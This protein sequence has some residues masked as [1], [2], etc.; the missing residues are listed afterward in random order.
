MRNKEHTKRKLIYA[1][2]QLIRKNGIGNL[3]ISQVSKLAEVDRKLIYRYFRN[4]NGL[5]EAYIVENDYWMK[6][7]DQAKKTIR[8]HQYDSIQILI[9][10]VLKNQFTFFF[11]EK[12]MQD[13]ILMELTGA[14]PLMKSIHNARESMGQSFLE[15]TD[16]HFK[17]SNVNFRAVA[18]LLVGGIYYTILHTVYNGGKFTDL[19][20]NTESAREE[21]LKAIEQIINWAY[22]EA[23]N[24]K[25]Q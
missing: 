17:G 11:N 4:L 23:S 25:M 21:L 19:D 24:T 6:Y 3:K 9:A 14:N 12:E 16:P 20:I 13:L 15:L 18:A 8:T 1:V 10:D 22:T 2:G 5:I 7:A